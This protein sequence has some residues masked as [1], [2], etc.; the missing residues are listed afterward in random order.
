MKLN[1]VASRKYVSSQ[2]RTTAL[3]HSNPPNSTLHKH[4]KDKTKERIWNLEVNSCIAIVRIDRRLGCSISY[5]GSRNL[6]SIAHSPVAPL[7]GLPA[8]VEAAPSFSNCFI[9]ANCCRSDI[10]VRGCPDVVTAGDDEDD[11]DG[12]AATESSIWVSGGVSQIPKRD[13]ML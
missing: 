12:E 2:K 5:F 4:L 3:E 10:G 1:K 8:E 7:S 6:C 13:G 9:I 11:G